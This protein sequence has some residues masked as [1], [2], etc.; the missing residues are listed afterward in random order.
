[1]CTHR[2]KSSTGYIFTHAHTQCTHMLNGMGQFSLHSLCFMLR[3]KQRRCIVFVYLLQ[4]KDNEKVCS[5]SLRSDGTERKKKR[6]REIE[7]IERENQS[8]SQ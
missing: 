3:A 6:E 4:L 2:D 8:E 1:M 5:S 7:K